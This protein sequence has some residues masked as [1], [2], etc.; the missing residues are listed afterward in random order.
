MNLLQMVD[1]VR[2]SVTGNRSGQAIGRT[3][4]PDHHRTETRQL[5]PRR[6]HGR[7]AESAEGGDA[8][9]PATQRSAI[10]WTAGP[11]EIAGCHH[12]AAAA[13]GG[14]ERDRWRAPD[15]VTVRRLIATR[16]SLPGAI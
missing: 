10:G 11:W 5:L 7:V 14:E 6:R 16:W 12:P 4:E 9:A 1:Q 3:C 15:V 8:A 2:P 13:D